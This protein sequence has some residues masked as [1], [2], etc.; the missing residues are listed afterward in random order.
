MWRR[1]HVD[2]W[3]PPPKVVPSSREWVIPSGL[4][5]SSGTKPFGSKTAAMLQFPR[6]RRI[7]WIKAAWRAMRPALLLQGRPW[8]TRLSTFSTHRH[9]WGTTHGAPIRWEVVSRNVPLSLDIIYW[10]CIHLNTEMP[11]T[12]IREHSVVLLNVSKSFYCSS[13]L[14]L[15]ACYYLSRLFPKHLCSLSQKC[16]ICYSLKLHIHIIIQEDFFL[17]FCVLLTEDRNAVKDL[18]DIFLEIRLGKVHCICK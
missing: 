17:N 8:G 11:A 3:Y 12:R 7:K 6:A 1:Q 2:A 15:G 9:R 16:N 4:W 13:P 18:L 14:S 5:P 10:N